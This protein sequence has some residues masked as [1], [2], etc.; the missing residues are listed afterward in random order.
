MGRSGWRWV[1]LVLGLAAG[2][3]AAVA[4][5]PPSVAIASID[6]VSMRGQQA[7]LDVTLSVHNSNGIDVPLHALR[8]RCSFDGAEVAQGVDDKPV[9]LP[10]GGDALVPVT[11]DV[12]AGT[13]LGVLAALPPS[14][15]V[16]YEI[17]GDAEIGL[18]MLR[19]PFDH[20]GSVRLR[21]R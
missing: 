21:I 18:T 17:Q 12:D 16:D 2:C 3:G 20:R 19:V 10:A 15:Q 1:L 7:R 9:S 6:H 14:G 5:E 11:L 4:M 8:F 13:L